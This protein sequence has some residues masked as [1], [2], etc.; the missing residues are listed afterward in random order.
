MSDTPSKKRWVLRGLLGLVAGVLVL[1]V[2]AFVVVQTP[3]AK[4]Q[5]RDLAQDLAGD[6]LNGR[7]VIGELSGSLLGGLELEGVELYDTDDVIVAR[8]ARAEATYAIWGALG[9]ELTVDS[10]KLSGVEL[11]ARQGAD[12]LNLAKLVKPS[13]EPSE[14]PQFNV[15]LPE[16]E[17][18]GALVFVNEEFISD[19]IQTIEAASTRVK[20]EFSEDSNLGALVVLDKL[21]MK[22]GVKLDLG[23]G[24]VVADLESLSTN[25]A[26][27]GVL[28]KELK[29]EGLSAVVAAE[30][31]SATLEEL[32]VEGVASI[33]GLAA[34]M[35]GEVVESKGDF[36]ILGEQDW[37][38]GL[39]PVNLKKG[40]KGKLKASGPLSA[41]D[42]GLELST[43]G[44]GKVSLEV[45]L[46]GI[47][48]EAEGEP[49]TKGKLIVS[50]LRAD[51]ILTEIP[52]TS[53]VNLELDFNTEGLD[54]QTLQAEAVMRLGVVEVDKYRLNSGEVN[55]VWKDSKVE[56]TRLNLDSP[57]AVAEL[58]GAY[59]LSGDL[60]IKG[61]LNTGDSMGELSKVFKTDTKV[62]G[63]LD[64]VGKLNLEETGIG[65]VET[66]AGDIRWDLREFS[67]EDVVIPE[68]RGDLKIDI[69]SPR[70]DTR[71]VSVK[72]DM[73]VR[74]ASAA[75]MRVGLAEAVF[76]LDTRVSK[77]FESLADFIQDLRLNARV[78]VAG[79]SGPG[80][81]IANSNLNLNVREIANS[82]YSYS[83]KTNNRA[84]DFG[85]ATLGKANAD[86]SGAVTINARKTGAQMVESISVRGDVEAESLKMQEERLGM[87]RANIQ[88]DG[89]TQD[90]KG[91]VDFSAQDVPVGAP[92]K[93]LYEFSDLVGQ[94]VLTG[95]REFEVRVSGNQVEGRAPQNIALELTGSYAPTLDDFEI[96][97]LSVSPGDNGWVI[98]NGMSFD[99]KR[100]IYRFDNVRLKQDEQEIQ[101][102][103]HL[104]MGVDQDVEGRVQGF[105]IED[106]P[107]QF[108]I[109]DFPPVKGQVD[110]TFS[111]KGTAKK[112]EALVDLTFTDLYW[113]DY[114]PFTIR[115]QGSYEDEL[116]R[117]Q[118]LEVE[119]YEREILAGAGSV[120]IRLETT[121]KW[122]IFWD[123]N[124]DLGVKL[125]KQDL[126]FF[127][128]IL[129]QLTMYSLEG[130]ASADVSI[131]GRV[132]SP[133]IE[134]SFL[135]ADAALTMPR[136]GS[137]LRLGPMRLRSKLSY[138]ESDA[139]GLDVRFEAEILDRNDEGL[140]IQAY[141]GLPVAEIVQRVLKGED[142][143]AMRAQI[144]N[145]PLRL[146]M[147]LNEYDV[148]RINIS[149]FRDA[150]AEGTI[151][152]QAMVQGTLGE[153]N[154]G[155]MFSL[156]GFGWDRF[157]DIELDIESNISEEMLEISKLRLEWDADEVFTGEAKVPFP[158]RYVFGDQDLQDLPIR[159]QFRIPELPVA[160]LSAMDYTF[161]SIRGTM[162]AE[163]NMAGSLSSP[164]F[165]M[166]LGIKDTLFANRKTGDLNFDVRAMFG[167][168]SVN[169]SVTHD[170]EKSAVVVGD[171]P[172]LTDI[173]ALAAGQS[174]L[175]EGDL[176]VAI[177]AEKTP[178][179]GL[180]PAR[181]LDRVM[182]QVKGTLDTDFAI[183]GTWQNIE[184]RGSFAIEGLNVFFPTLGRSVENGKLRI[185]AQKNYLDVEE[186]H[187][188][189]S[190]SSVDMS[191][192]IPIANMIPTG[193]KINLN[194]DN[195]ATTGFTPMPVYVSGNV[196]LDAD[197]TQELTSANVTV[198]DLVLDVPQNNQSNAHPLDVNSDIVILERAEMDAGMM[199]IP[200]LA[201]LTAGGAALAK[202]QVSIAPESQLRHPN[203]V[204]RFRG[205]LALDVDSSGATILGEIQTSRGEVEFLGKSF[206]VDQGII[207]FTGASP[208][209]PRIQVEASYALDRAVTDVVG[210]AT[211]GDPRAV[212]RVSGTA[213][214]PELRMS[215][216]PQMTESQIIYV[217]VSDRPP[218]NA[219]GEEEG[220][221]SQA[222][223]AASGILSGMLKERAKGFYP[224]DMLRLRTD[225]TG[226]SGVEVGKYFG[227][228][229]FFAYEYVFGADEGENTN[230][231]RLEYQFAPSWLVGSRF[232]DQA[233]GALFLYWDIF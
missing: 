57:Y 132:S 172:I 25:V 165:D 228:N 150:K 203:A 184:P 73:R 192:R 214:R 24:G 66:L 188:E 177:K 152:V 215:S 194:L 130:E 6:S 78:N 50:G 82:R 191:G 221:A 9:G 36:E 140:V 223:A 34:S 198:N 162:Q 163:M 1:V 159:A 7:L 104:H 97:G 206:R 4:G 231:V 149:E 213:L 160:K 37:L 126:S 26:V 216:D 84:L 143:G 225:E 156:S 102:N 93:R 211:S 185:T 21:A 106:L 18:E 75:G 31:L 180:L 22:A 69:R 173:L 187:I 109:Q 139:E 210:P 88:V 19:D 218:T 40:V 38:D 220:V 53:L 15:N 121:G 224:V 33:T 98:E 85:S 212:I 176:A 74:R 46:S 41:L 197:L 193:A 201:K 51:E 128:E 170:G 157:R 72:G 141:S 195:V 129:P 13:E 230:E 202:I 16:I 164:E 60:A 105:K 125:Q 115:I 226:I 147:Q 52:L 49:K 183:G 199:M 27:E 100:G 86:L 117:V 205:D 136:Q 232:G 134:A 14:P 99:T 146:N 142:I 138:Q 153:P 222:V 55:A 154:A 122:E 110:G 63:N 178:L 68:S 124:F 101:I 155:L 161:A 233:N 204:V 181:I 89:P 44:A 71:S 167:R 186:M 3:W 120:P 45:L 111:L 95:K 43:D 48:A 103:G 114:G 79:L 20:P 131:R 11:Y 116:L 35:K 219:A 196:A 127:S 47:A 87:V 175:A 119:G 118:T 39:S 29:I 23:T 77:P 81:R 144:L 12:G 148:Q 92:E 91:T 56:I 30:S 179:A 229:V 217:L 158:I 190:N 145:S 96:H 137:D 208:P 200:D 227:K 61:S 65:L 8:V 113:E 58:T 169:M 67:M 17:L 108:G 135:L 28:Q 59:S 174:P 62:Q 209:N 189:E 168:A 80:I 90:L 2:L 171:F 94:L 54:P 133:E 112:P 107:N 32:K 83:V 76:D 166:V 123:R 207:A 5:I 42:V 182:T 10:V 64:L 70:P 151:G